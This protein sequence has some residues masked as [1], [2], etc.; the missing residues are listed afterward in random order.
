[1]FDRVRV[2]LLRLL[3][4]H[5]IAEL[6]DY[7]MGFNALLYNRLA[8]IPGNPYRVHKSR[9]HHDGKLCFGGDFFIVMVQSPK[10]Q[11][12]NHYPVEQ[13]KYFRIPER[14]VSEEWDKH[15]PQV[16]LQRMLE[17]ALEGPDR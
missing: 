9:K 17:W 12:S 6:Y 7:R 11:I 16:A 13:W 4:D 8:A 15:T 3:R 10:G 14:E 2:W 5:E 1:M